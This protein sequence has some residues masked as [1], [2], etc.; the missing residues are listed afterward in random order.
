L[1]FSPGT[2]QDWPAIE[3][4]AVTRSQ[5]NASVAVQSRSGDPLIAWQRSGQGRVVA[6]TCGLG[7]WTP[8]WLRWR[9][10]PLLAGGLI[11]WISGAPQGGA[12]AVSDLPA[13]LRIEADVPIATGAP[14]AESVS[15]AVKTPSGQDR[16]VSADYVAPGRL[17]ATLTDTA[18]GLYAFQVPTSLGTKRHLHL[19][20]NRA[21]SETWGTNPALYAWKT[22]GLVGD[23]D[24]GFLA[25]QRFGDRVLRP[26]DRSLLGLA[27]AL[28]L[29]A[30]L[31]DR[32]RRYEAGARRVATA[33]RSV[34][35]VMPFRQGPA[36]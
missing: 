8:Q 17:R 12:L 27:L 28:F 13:G 4:Y 34:A 11:E 30:V 21:E 14:D 3:A 18:S 32:S 26:V 22:D 24:P 35:S 1:P 29:A 31:V 2:L 6:V 33:L 7:R 23:W 36:R 16:L 20:R 9:E 10:W 15:I 5:P 19:R 25:Q